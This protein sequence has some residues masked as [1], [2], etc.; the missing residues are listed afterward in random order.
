MKIR[1]KCYALCKF[2]LWRLMW[3]KS[4]IIWTLLANYPQLNLFQEGQE[5]ILNNIKTYSATP[6]FYKK[7]TN[8]NSNHAILPSMLEHRFSL[9]EACLG[10]ENTFKAAW[11][12]RTFKKHNLHNE[13]Q[14]RVS[15][16]GISL[17]GKLDVPKVRNQEKIYSAALPSML[18]NPSSLH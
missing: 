3:T 1:I 11:N 7:Q 5:R 2:K 4:I 6:H 16:H 10:K 12:I 13:R 8:K 17:M 14:F 9:H 15:K 18:D